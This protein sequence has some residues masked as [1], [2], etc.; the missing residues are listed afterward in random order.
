MLARPFP[1]SFIMFQTQTRSDVLSCASLVPY[2]VGLDDDKEGFEKVLRRLETDFGVVA[3]D[4]RECAYQWS[5]P[6]SWAP[7]NFVAF[8]AAERLSL[9]NVATR[10]AEKYTKATEQLFVKTGKLW[11]KYNA[12]NGELDYGSEYGTPAMLGWT[13]GVYVV[14]QQYLEKAGK[15]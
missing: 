10:I 12:E 3:C 9:V 7:L 8:C 15:R 1:G 13:A 14:C 2:F 6:N 5:A 4:S 11:E